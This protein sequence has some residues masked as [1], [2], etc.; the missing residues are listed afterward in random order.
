M[1]SVIGLIIYHVN[2][3]SHKTIL[4]PVRLRPFWKRCRTVRIQE[5]HTNKKKKC[6]PG[7]HYEWKTAVDRTN[8]LWKLDIRGNAAPVNTHHIMIKLPVPSL[9]TKMYLHNNIVYNIQETDTKHL[10]L[11]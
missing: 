10:S 3:R 9:N 11:W 6:F 1:G 2:I 4:F 8:I 7:K 5:S